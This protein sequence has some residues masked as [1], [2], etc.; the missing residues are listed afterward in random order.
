M[1]KWCGVHTCVL[2]VLGLLV[3]EGAG[4]LVI[5]SPHP[6]A[7]S[8]L[9]TP[10]YSFGPRV[11]S[12][13]NATLTVLTDPTMALRLCVGHLGDTVRGKVVAFAFPFATTADPSQDL[14]VVQNIPGCAYERMISQCEMAGCAGFVRLWSDESLYFNSP[15][16]AQ[17]HWGCN[18]CSVLNPLRPAI[19]FP[20]AQAQLGP[21]ALQLML[22]MLGVVPPPNN[23]PIVIPDT[24]VSMD[25]QQSRFQY[26]SSTYG[27]F[28]QVFLACWCVFNATFAVFGLAKQF[29]LRKVS[30]RRPWLAVTALSL[31]LLAQVL[32]FIL[33]VTDPIFAWGVYLP[34]YI[35]QIWI[36]YFYAVSLLA[37]F[38]IAFYWFRI[39]FSMSRSFNMFT[40][41]SIFCMVIFSLLILAMEFVPLMIEVFSTV[42]VQNTLLGRVI[43]LSIL[44]WALAAFFIVS[45]TRVLFIL[46]QGNRYRASQTR[47]QKSMSVFLIVDAF[48]LIAF[49]CFAY[50]E[51]AAVYVQTD[52]FI[53]INTVYFVLLSAISSAQILVFALTKPH[54]KSNLSGSAVTATGNS[55]TATTTTGGGRSRDEFIAVDEGCCGIPKRKRKSRQSSTTGFATEDGLS[56]DTSRLELE[57]GMSATDIAQ[58]DQP[59]PSSTPKRIDA[60]LKPN[61]PKRETET[62][63]IDL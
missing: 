42:Y 17:F 52:G 53:A 28:L 27:I 9:L 16:P 58:D 5:P 54:E 56:I 32:R 43:A 57:S 47:Y 31:E 34:S 7:G 24:L 37:T 8:F 19:T 49:G 21:L 25:A 4:Q 10:F 62:G 20:V 1:M 29:R 61:S 26:L 39:S 50:A 41:L 60:D 30:S 59:P 55:T 12:I 13:R 45:G 51:T 3:V 6:L 35:V 63:Y 2:L 23:T 38:Y 11:F 18:N 33:N 22:V 46:Y 40:P 48:L 15:I 36:S 14:N 44:C